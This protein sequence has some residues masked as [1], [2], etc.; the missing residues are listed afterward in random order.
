MRYSSV[1]TTFLDDMDF[2][3]NKSFSSDNDKIIKNNKIIV[4]MKC[5]QKVEFRA[6]I[7]LF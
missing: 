7:I 3:R 2:L 1:I 6:Q 4:C 5:Y